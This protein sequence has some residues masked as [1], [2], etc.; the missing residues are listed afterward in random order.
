MYA[1]PATA[2]E[3]IERARSLGALSTPGGFRDRSFV[4][5]VAKGHSI[6]RRGG[7]S[8]LMNR[9][10]AQLV[11]KPAQAAPQAAAPANPADQSGGWAAWTSWT[12]PTGNA[13]SSFRT[14]WTVPPPPASQSG[15]LIYLFNGLQDPA[16]A[17][18]LQPVL[19]WGE[20]GAGGGNSWFVASWHVDSKGH[21]FCTPAIPVEPGTQVTGV[22]SLIAT[23][24][25]GTHNY[26]CAFDGIDDTTLIAQ[27]LGD[28]PVAEETLEAYGVTAQDQY[29]AAASIDMTA[30]D[31]EVGGTPA[32]LSW[33]PFNLQNPTLGEHAVVGSN[34]NPGGQVSLFT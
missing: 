15:Q 7:R 8:Y 27:G 13:I 1:T 3:L 6:V 22:I 9:E 24:A 33:A 12:N 25:D 5:R 26:S 20:S 28:L 11:Q 2:N 31:I 21:A 17:E 18:I 14:T 29:P 4:H 16:G 19:Q 23:F 30:I 34:A 32:V 10:T